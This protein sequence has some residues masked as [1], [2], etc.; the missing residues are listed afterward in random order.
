M[1]LTNF[2]NSNDDDDKNAGMNSFVG[3]TVA[4]TGPSSKD[5]DL[6]DMLI[7]MNKSVHTP[8][9]FRDE[10]IKQLISILIGSQKPNALLIGSAGTGKTAIVEE[11]ATMIEHKDPRVP[12]MLHGKTIYSLQLSDLIA[13][14]Q[15]RGQLEDKIKELVDFI[16]DKK[17]NAI[18]F[19]D[20]IHQLFGNNESYKEIAQI[21]KP[22]LSRGKIHVIGATTTQEVKSLEKDPAFNRR[23][24]RV[25]VDELSKEQ[26]L[27]ILQALVPSLVKHY[28]TTFATSDDIFKL[29]I[30]IA[31]EYCSVGS[32]RPDNAITLLDRA[33][34]NAVMDKQAMFNNPDPNV[35]AAAK[36]MQGVILSETGIRKTALKITTGNNEPQEF[37]EER[38]K[39]DFAVIKGQDSILEPLLRMMKIHTMH[40][41]PVKKPLTL[42]FAGASGV[43]KTEVTKILAHNYLNE[44][45]IILNM[46]EYND[47]ASINRIIGAPAGY[48]GYD[49]NN[50]LPFDSL[51]TNPYQ[52][53]LLDEFEKCNKSV[54]RLFMRVFDEGQLLTNHGKLIDFTKAIIIATTNAGC[55]VSNNIGFNSD[56][57][58]SKNLSKLTDYFDVE[59]LNRFTKKY[60]FN[61]IEK[62]VFAD[63]MRNTYA[64]EVAFIKQTKPRIPLPD[65][66][67]DAN[68][69]M[70]VEQHYEPRFGA[71]PI[72]QV[73]IEFI[74]E[75]LV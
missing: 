42:L 33:I 61:N 22:V 8:C 70:L 73:I 36:A 58:N 66:L 53:I 3:G 49:D 9:L 29:L 17:N 74:D 51:T 37:D 46:T 25:L 19:I 60:Y 34:A 16:S 68:L 59:L 72:K 30:N 67:D 38:F 57:D 10:V 62:D 48:V 23:F 31:D 64:K 12:S 52:V 32:H 4:F 15:F 39:A 71:R 75:Q 2:S 1:G 50:E 65:D 35:Q 47:S 11:L 69:A 28:G 45:P 6:E 26:T 14:T 18:L 27:T 40:L 56:K 21:L 24:T 13:G 55:T 7:N 54:Q 5:N 44:K 20:E 43:G 63:I 41:H